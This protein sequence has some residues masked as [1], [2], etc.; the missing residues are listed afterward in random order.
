MSDIKQLKEDALFIQ[1]GLFKIGR[2]RVV[3]LP[4]HKTWELTDEMEARMARLVKA[5]ESM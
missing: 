1:K 4:V 5:V 3:A 2:H